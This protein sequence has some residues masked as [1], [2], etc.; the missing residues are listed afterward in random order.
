MCPEVAQV[1]GASLQHRLMGRRGACGGHHSWLWGTAC[2]PWAFGPGCSEECRCEQPHTQ[3]C[4][5]RDGSCLCKAGFRGERCQAGACPCGGG[6]GLRCPAGPQPACHPA[7][8]E[9][10]FFGPGCRQACT[11]PPGVACDPAS[12]E[13]WQQC[14]PGYH[15]Q[16][17]GQ[18]EGLAPGIPCSGGSHECHMAGSHR[19][20]IGSRY[21]GASR[22]ELGPM[23]SVLG[24]PQ[25][26]WLPW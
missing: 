22:L 9:P 19:P 12:G 7:E 5:R 23:I 10:G 18:G 26:S 6:A 1:Q 20:E 11:C 2:P 25:Q 17:C 14:P 24:C 15:G 16:D 21:R 3:S 8:C 4:D 13:C